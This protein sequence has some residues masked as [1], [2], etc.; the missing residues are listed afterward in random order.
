MRVA[1]FHFPAGSTTL[2]LAPIPRLFVSH[3]SYGRRGSGQPQGLLPRTQI[4]GSRGASSI[5]ELM[6]V[7]QVR[8]GLPVGSTNL[9]V[10]AAGEYK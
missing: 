2:F 4:G 8:G 9:P 1:P 5:R 6:L 10:R 7:T 3:G